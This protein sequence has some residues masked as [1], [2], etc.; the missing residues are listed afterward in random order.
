MTQSE[1]QWKVSLTMAE[2]YEVNGKEFTCTSVDTKAQILR[3]FNHKTTPDLPACIAI[4][5]TGSFPVAFQAKKWKKEWGKYYVHFKSS[6]REI[7]ITGHRFTD[8]GMLANFPVKYLN[9]EDMRP[10]YFSHIHSEDNLFGFGINGL[11][12]SS[13]D[14]RS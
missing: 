4:Q 14:I 7:D 11:Q 2:L 10:M 9:N 3:F 12:S 13:L 8:G 6:R 1:D 5:M